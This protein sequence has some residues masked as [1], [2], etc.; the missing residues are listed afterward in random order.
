MGFRSAQGRPR[1]GDESMTS[2]PYQIGLLG[3]FGPYQ[4]AIE[5]TASTRFSELGFQKSDLRILTGPAV[6]GRQRRSPFAA[7]FFGYPG[8]GAATHPELDDVLQDSVVVL[9][10]V[11]Q[12]QGFT[13]NIPAS[14]HHVQGYVHNKSDQH[15]EAEVGT[16]LENFRLLRRDRRL[17]ISYK[18]SDSSGI[19]A[20][21]YD[22]LDRRGFDV[23]LDT[24]GVP[25]GKDFQSV[26]WHRLADSDVVVVLDTPHFFESRWT[27]EELARA[28]ATNIQVLHVL[29]PGRI[30]SPRSA[31]SDFLR[32]K[33]KMFAGP[34]L[35]ADAKL[36]ASVLDRV[37][38]KVEALRA[39]ALT[40]RHRF[41][42]DAFCDAAKERKLE[43][44]VQP[45][46]HILLDAARGR[47]AV[48][49]M[50]GVPSALRLYDIHSELQGGPIGQSRIW[51]LYDHRGLLQEMIAHLD[52]LNIS[53]PVSAVSVYEVI[54][55][56]DAERPP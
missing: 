16:I 1:L 18:R 43:V 22:V 34:Q 19:A 49:P 38:A 42:V 20:Q 36:E 27:E 6:I 3:N 10:V 11:E 44:D 8:A 21:L 12:S 14:L 23:F 39:R 5:K 33:R 53:L 55:R 37:S 26:L 28:N 31:L 52:W 2:F 46:R 40:A 17:F 45:S 50:V 7:I 9:P 48:V 13:A 32:L 30:L 29:W 35:G 56:L 4:K 15:F 25:P 41:L 47:I 24:R 54:A 51:A